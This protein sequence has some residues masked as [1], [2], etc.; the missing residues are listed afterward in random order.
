MDEERKQK[1]GLQAVALLN[2]DLMS[3]ETVSGLGQMRADRTYGVEHFLP[4]DVS[5]HAL[6]EAVLDALSKSRFISLEEY[7]T[8]FNPELCK[9]QYLEWE[10]MLRER[11]GYKTKR[12][13]YKGMK[14]VIIQKAN[15]VLRFSPSYQ[16]RSLDYWSGKG[17][18]PEDDVQLP[19]TSSAEEIG[20]ALRLA[21]SRCKGP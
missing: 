14:N 1:Q 6:G 8:F 15:D 19:A 2:T 4:P 16:E 18:G 10:Q 12:A 11:F 17:L 5:N 7:K 9:Q 13:L 21:F 20:A 3:V